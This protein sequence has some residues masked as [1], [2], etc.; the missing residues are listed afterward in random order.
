MDF[1]AKP[2][3]ERERAF[4][5]LA[6]ELDDDKRRELLQVLFTPEERRERAEKIH[7]RRL[8]CS[9]EAIETIRRLWSDLQSRRRSPEL[10]SLI[11]EYS[12]EFLASKK[13]RNP[14]AFIIA[15]LLEDLGI[16]D[17]KPPPEPR[18]LSE[19]EKADRE[20]KKMFA[21]A[22]REQRGL[23][24]AESLEETL[25]WDREVLHDNC[26]RIPFPPR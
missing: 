6:R 25:R 21:E 4:S 18:P 19:S 23:A 9:E 12:A 24:L 10:H 17:R 8:G 5:V 15:E 7:L 26:W 22:D 16:K 20:L 3:Q 13:V 1:T 14:A 11:L 2:L